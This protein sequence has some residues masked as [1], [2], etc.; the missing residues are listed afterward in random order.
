MKFYTNSIRYINFGKIFRWETNPLKKK[1]DYFNVENID[2]SCLA[3]VVVNPKEYFEAFESQNVNK[4]HKGLRK[5]GLGMVFE[6]YSKRINSIK[7][8]ETFGQLP[9][10]KSKQNRFLIK[11]NEMI[12]EEIEKSKFS[13]INYKRYYFSDGIVSLPFSHPYL[14]KIVQFKRDKN[15]KIESFLREEKHKLIQMEK[16]AVEKNTRISFYRSILQQKPTFYHLDSLKR[17]IENNQNINLSP[18]TRSYILNGFWQ[19]AKN[20]NTTGHFPTIF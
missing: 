3:T 16:F 18:R 11:K 2:D 8:F 10:K 6:N 12:L 19:W 5:G 7:K 4:K 15:Q 20:S 14:D 9:Q 1:L 17:S 13:Q